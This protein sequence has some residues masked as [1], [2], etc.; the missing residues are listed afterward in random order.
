M[1]TKAELRRAVLARQRSLTTDERIQRSQRICER[2]FADTDLEL[3]QYLHCF[4]SI[5]KFNEIDTTPIF[6]RLWAEF[7][8]VTTV[9]P[10][11]D[12]ASGE[13]RHLNFTRDT[14]LVQ[15]VWKI[16]EPTHNEFVGTDQ[17]DM[18]LVP[19]LCVDERGHR[20]GYGKGFY[21]R[22][23]GKCR[24]DCLK[25]ALNYFPPVEVISDVGPHDVTVD[26]CVT[27]DKTYSFK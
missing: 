5:D 14:E 24:P 12:I 16:H 17:I 11:V 7:P 25:I 2:F 22:F 10:R 23:L 19:S 6:Q 4:I 3:V 1:M 20:V 9:V 27:P 26:R 15:N 13:M 18:V 8:A 21:D